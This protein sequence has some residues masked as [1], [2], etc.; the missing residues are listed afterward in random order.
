MRFKKWIAGLHYRPGGLSPWLWPL[1]AFEALYA[2][3][4]WIRLWCYRFGW[5]HTYASGVPIV[6]VG[7]L[8]TGGTGKTPIIVAI[9]RGLI[10]A[11]K[12]VVILSR[13]YGA[14]KQVD[15]TRAMD[16]AYGDE[17]YMIQAQVPEAV[18]IVGKDRIST[19]KRA[20]RDFRPDFVLLDDGYQYIKLKRA[21]NI[22]LIDGSRL[23]GNGHLLPVGPL[24]EPLS[25]LARA[26]LV[27]ITKQVNQDIMRT[28]ERWCSRAFK[29]RSTGTKLT[30]DLHSIGQSAERNFGADLQA[31][32]QSQ[33]PIPIVPIE[34]QAVGFRE[35][36]DFQSLKARP[37]PFQFFRSRPVVAF[38]GIANPEQFA[39]DLTA[40]G[41]R[42]LRHFVF[43]DHHVYTQAEMDEILACFE[44]NRQSNPILVTTD[45]DLPKVSAFFSESS[46][47]SALYTLQLLP[48]LD[49]RWFY[50]EFLTQMPGFRQTDQY[51]ESSGL[52]R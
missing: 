18:V 37:Q 33:S 47:A 25:Q 41:L 9:A 26:D 34:F 16:P 15:Y 24:R 43:E 39:R 13:G 5:L 4:I 3:A 20:L 40:Q 48:A 29:A 36:A 2:L 1:L 32:S 46:H 17:A 21:I 10:Q 23:I 6:S 28:V 30:I 8:T 22:L 51:A 12:T 50:D 45:K 35:M 7:N 49:G 19:L 11:N 42:L 52:G 44:L 27:F 31:A 14:E 38:S